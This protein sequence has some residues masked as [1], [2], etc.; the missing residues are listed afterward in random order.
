MVLTQSIIVIIDDLAHAKPA[1]KAAANFAAHFSLP[2]RVIGFCYEATDN[3]PIDFTAE[4]LVDIRE[5]SISTL[6]AGLNIMCEKELRGSEYYTESI[7]HK[8]PDEYLAS[9]ASFHA[10]L[11]IKTRHIDDDNGFSELDWKLIRSTSAPLYFVADRPWSHDNNVFC[12]VDLGSK[13]LSKYNLNKRIIDFARTFS[14]FYQSQFYLGY[15]ISIS[16]LLR[17]LGFVFPDEVS[18]NAVK[19]LP[20]RQQQLL[21]EYAID[22]N[23]I[24]KVGKPELV[25]PSQAAKCNAGLVVMGTVG[26]SGLKGKLLGNTA[27][28]VLRLLRTDLLVISPDTDD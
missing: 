10:S 15:A 24:I 7:W 13:R 28:R 27:E 21:E 11:V 16:P 22:E 17:D 5:R 1:L 23:L 8:Y 25:I 4:Q 2:I 14:N 12:C 6:D 20:S 26:R 19:N 18:L 3:L 9:A